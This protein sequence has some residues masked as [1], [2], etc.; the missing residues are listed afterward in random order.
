MG[1]IAFNITKVSAE[2]QQKKTTKVSNSFN[3]KDVKKTKLAL[4]EQEQEVASIGFSFASTFEPGVGQIEFEGNVLHL[5]KP[6]KLDELVSTWEKDKS[7]PKAEAAMIGNHI[8][9]KTQVLSIMLAR[10]MNL[11]SPVEMPRLSTK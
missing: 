11:P 8:L 5:D 2:A 3:I 1:I 6:E 9:S 4:G 10:E 7:L